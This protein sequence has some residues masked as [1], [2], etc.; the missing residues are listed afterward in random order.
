[1]TARLVAD[2]A[3]QPLL[4]QYFNLFGINRI[5][6]FAGAGHDNVNTSTTSVSSVVYLGSGNDVATTGGGRDVVYGE[7]GDDFATLGENDDYFGGGT[8]NDTGY[9][10]AGNDVLQGEADW[11]HLFG[12]AGNDEIDGG[13]GNDE[14]RG[15]D[16][17]DVLRG[18]SGHDDLFGSSGADRLY[19]A[20]GDDELDG[21]SNDDFLNGGSGLDQLSGSSGHDALIGG[22]NNDRDELRGGSGH[23]RFLEW[24]STSSGSFEN[25]LDV[26]SEDAIIYFRNSGQ[27]DVL[28]G[29]NVGW[30]RYNA[31][32]W[33]ESEIE[34]AD[35]AF[36]LL[37][38]KT[39]NTRLLKTNLGWDLTFNRA[40]SPATN[41]SAA[42]SIGGWNSGIG[43][44]T[45]TQFSIGQGERNIQRV[46]L[47]EIAHNWDDEG[48]YW[49]RFKRESG[50]EGNI[51]IVHDLFAPDG[52]VKS[53]DGGWWRDADADSAREYGRMNPMEDWATMWE[54]YFGYN[55]TNVSDKAEVLDDFFAHMASLT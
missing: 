35:G 31:G 29:S 43:S 18:S 28:L 48:A 26:V 40:G 23:D 55:G 51:P 1:V 3:G 54:A 12:D 17:N 50:W 47:H 44:M 30:T 53:D 5:D 10:G 22:A 7:A 20:D 39:G 36:L 45:F 15:A 6:V 21:G 4:D 16:G 9:G 42:A 34:A 38:N 25:R 52:K 13:G 8:F 2:A 41:T 27:Q 46:V 24:S 49:D 11:D 37:Q 19:G 32:T 14:L 33:S